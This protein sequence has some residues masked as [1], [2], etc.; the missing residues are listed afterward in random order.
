MNLSFG[1]S[2]GI[3]LTTGVNVK[4]KQIFAT[5]LKEK[6]PIAFDLFKPFKPSLVLARK[7]TKLKSEALQDAPLRWS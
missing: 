5:Y 2:V 3:T 6:Y 1:L 7:A 4:N